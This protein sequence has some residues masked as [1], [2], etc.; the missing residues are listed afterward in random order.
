MNKLIEIIAEIFKLKTP[1]SLTIHFD[2]Q[3]GYKLESKLGDKA[4]KDLIRGWNRLDLRL[5]PQ[6]EI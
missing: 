6:V 1:L 5:K 4:V 2:G 3:G